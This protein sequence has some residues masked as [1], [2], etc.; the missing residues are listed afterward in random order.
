MS[1]GRRSTE[2]G[3][4]NNVTTQSKKKPTNSESSIE[5]LSEEKIHLVKEGSSRQHHGEL[6]GVVGV[7]EP[8]LVVD[9]PGVVPPR[10]AHNTIPG[11]TPHPTAK[12]SKMSVGCPKLK[13]ISG[14]N[15]FSSP[16]YYC[17]DSQMVVE[18]QDPFFFST[19][20]YS[21]KKKHFQLYVPLNKCYIFSRNIYL[22]IPFAKK[23]YNSTQ[24]RDTIKTA[25]LLLLR[26]TSL[27]S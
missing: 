6:T 8:G 18:S 11:L 5:K 13:N 19:Q 21:T 22:K 27:T 4:P 2:R 1:T 17:S 9:V 15:V 14:D 3:E 26:A 7:V 20:M 23:K 12:P 16:L 24:S 25:L 10:E